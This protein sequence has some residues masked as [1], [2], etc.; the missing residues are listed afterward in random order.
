MRVPTEEITEERLERWKR[1]LARDHATPMVL[2]AVGHDE[3]SGKLFVCTV[4][5]REMDS[6]TVAA[7]L[8]AAVHQVEKHHRAF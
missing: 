5:D 8:R 7:F 6:S 4:E 2:L 3:Q 1:L